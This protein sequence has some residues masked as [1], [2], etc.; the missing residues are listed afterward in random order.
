MAVPYDSGRH[1]HV[2]LLDQAT[3][4]TELASDS[5]YFTYRS[6]SDINV[7]APTIAQLGQEML[8]RYRLAMPQVLDHTLHPVGHTK[9]AV[10]TTH[11]TEVNAMSVPGS[12]WLNGFT[13][14]QSS[15]VYL[16]LLHPITGDELAYAQKSFNFSTFDGSDINITAPSAGD[17]YA[18]DDLIVSLSYASPDSGYSSPR[19]AYHISTSSYTSSFGATQVTSNTVDSSSWLSGVPYDS[20]RHLHV[21]LLDQATGTTE[22]AS[23]S[24]YFNY[25][26]GSAPTQSPGG[27]YQT[28]SSGY[29][30]PDG[31]SIHYPNVSI[32]YSSDYN[33]MQVQLE[34]PVAEQ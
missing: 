18:G 2:Y 33:G 15:T 16:A 12:Q 23:D 5:I 14:G 8:C 25:R 19:W 1:L 21:Y 24:I 34:L 6:G 10:V 9:L 13:N 26:S 30:S 31:I 3:G 7:T 17:V 32:L 27:G 28:P 4:T 20:G 11:G 22:L 29:Q